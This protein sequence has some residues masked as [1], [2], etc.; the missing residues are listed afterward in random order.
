MMPVTFDGCAGW[1]NVGSNGIGVVICAPFGQE[2]MLTYRGCK[3]LADALQKRGF[4]VLRFDYPGTGDSAGSETDPDRLGAWQGSIGSATAFLRHA[5]GADAMLL[6]GFRLG[7]AL[8]LRAA[9]MD[10]S[11]IAICC[12]SPVISGRSYTRELRL[13]ANGWREANLLPPP[14][15]GSAHLDVAGDRLA[16]ETLHA[17][18]AIDLRTLAQTAPD[19]L[20]MEASGAPLI[21]ALANRLEELG[22]RVT[23][24]D[25]PGAPEFLQNPFSATVPQAAFTNIVEWCA[26]LLPRD[27][28]LPPP[29]PPTCGLLQL[30][31]AIEQGLH[32]GP[33]S[34]LYG[35][36]CL[37]MQR[38]VDPAPTV[39]MLNTGFGRRTGD[40]RVY[41]TL[42]R[43]LAA[44]G[45]ASLRID[46]AGFGD[47]TSRDDQEA[48]PYGLEIVGDVVAGVEVLAARGL[49]RPVLVG[50]CSGAHAAFHAGLHEPRIDRLILTNLQKFIWENDVPLRVINRKQRRPVAFYL[51]AATR[52]GVWLRLL[53]GEIAVGSI[54]AALIRR[55]FANAYIS[56][57]LLLERKMG[58]RTHSG[59]VRRWLTEL[60]ERGTHV[61]LLYSEG[62]PGLSE[63]ALVVGPGQRS[64]QGFENINVKVIPRADHALLD[65]T[66]RQHFIDYICRIFEASDANSAE[67]VGLSA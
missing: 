65:H 23:R 44:L 38:H 6:I 48:D 64:L 33:R 21:A 37:P 29:L 11:I 47:S 7:A 49:H 51:R 14:Q 59:Q 63:L 60:D 36:L 19:V 13:L 54:G 34:S 41:V 58:L 24:G 55:L 43:R 16:D 28:R 1:L 35:V 27:R 56:G 15:T 25:F 4:S 40:G 17:L 10:P 39:L 5:T 26:S 2:A 57:C 66:A 52:Q 18:S 12:L 67:S 22:A 3:I 50:I 53:C 62:D 30:P 42:A 61:D 32:F 45:I 20:L 8:A 31:N 46:A 9:A